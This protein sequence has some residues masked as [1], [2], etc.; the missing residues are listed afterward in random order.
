MPLREKEI[1]FEDEIKRLEKRR[2]ELAEKIVSADE[3]DP[4]RQRWAQR[5]Q[6]LDAHLDGLEW[7]LIAHECPSD[8]HDHVCP[9]VPHW[10]DHK[11]EAVTLSGLDGGE[12]GGMESDLA[13]AAAESSRSSE[14]AERIFQVR[15][16]TVNA[17]YVADDMTDTEEIIAVGDLPIGFLKW[18]EY[19]I[20]DLSSVGNGDRAD[21]GIL[22]AE[23]QKEQ[24]AE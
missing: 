2:D 18:A 1:R 23:K 15:A 10:P 9:K 3:E 22:L 24:S 12:Y 16:G 21:F 20:D 13:E 5:G 8:D 14:G 4:R 19:R 6:E 11:V 17:P 7:A